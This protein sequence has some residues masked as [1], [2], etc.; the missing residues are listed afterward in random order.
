MEEKVAPV[1]GTYMHTISFMEMHSHK[2]EGRFNVHAW[3]RQ[4]CMC[5]HA[6]GDLY[7]STS[8]PE[9]KGDN[10][11]EVFFDLEAPYMFFIF[12]NI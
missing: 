11:I 9:K 12:F 2:N 3:S 10:P 4:R 7:A 1:A 8:E 5:V 6:G